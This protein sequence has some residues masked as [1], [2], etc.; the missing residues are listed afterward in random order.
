MKYEYELNAKQ[1]NKFNNRK[2]GV[3]YA[4]FDEIYLFD[5]EKDTYIDTVQ[6]KKYAHSALADQTEEDK[7]L[8][9][10]HKG[11]LNGIDNEVKKAQVDIYNKAVSIAPEAAYI[12]NP[13]LT[14]KADFNEYLRNGNLADFAER[15]GIRPQDVSEISVYCEKN[16]IEPEDKKKNKKA[17][18]PFLT[19]ETI[20]LSRFD[21]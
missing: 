6:R 10:K 8:Q 14:P 18:S 1:F 21:Y 9:F 5:L 3:R 4:T 20:D 13:L 17:E 15:H 7:I 16:S 12:M 19:D 11:R 2:F